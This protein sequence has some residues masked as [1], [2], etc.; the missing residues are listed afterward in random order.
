M[1]ARHTQSP[2]ARIALLGIGAVGCVV[3]KAIQSV[4]ATRLTL[5]DGDRVEARNLGRQHYYRTEDIGVPKVHAAA[6]RVH[7]EAIPVDAFLSAVNAE[8]LLADHDLVIDCT[9]DL[10]AKDL[11]DRACKRLMIPLISGGAHGTQAQ[12]ILMPA[13]S[14]HASARRPELF[15]G[16]IGDEQ[17]GCDMSQVPAGVINALGER[18]AAAAA[19]FL[20]N[21]SMPGP[22][23]ELFDARDGLWV[24]YETAAAR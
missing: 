8:A 5:I 17:S 7:G 18:I 10:F 9:D 6:S 1:S 14:V 12:C 11:I 21:R 16:R 4:G 20:E 22:V 2:S 15:S 24:T 13:P 23:V 19:H 3:I